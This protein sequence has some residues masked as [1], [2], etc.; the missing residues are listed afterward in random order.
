MSLQA[1]KTTVREFLDHRDLTGVRRW[2]ASER[3]PLRTLLS[4]TFDGQELIRW[5]AV[6][7]VG[8]VA[9][10][11]ARLDLDRVREFL[12]RLLWLMNDESGGLS[13]LSP[14]MIGEILVNVPSLIEEYGPLLLSFLQEEPFERGSHLAIWRVA[15]IRPELFKKFIAQLRQSL[16]H[17][18]PAIRAFAAAGIMTIDS[19]QSETLAGQL[20][21]DEAGFELYE[22]TNGEMQQTTVARMVT[23]IAHARSNP[24]QA[25]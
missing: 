13:R 11:Q 5:R 9:V 20:G 4:L 22:F 17:P 3:S 18:D 19:T 14:E 21:K 24:E 1:R 2:A 15:G 23:R 25:A 8:A 7:A 6:E 16:G 12:R 10:D